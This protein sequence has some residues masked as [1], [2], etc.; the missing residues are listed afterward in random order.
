MEQK[1]LLGRERSG[2]VNLSHPQ[3]LSGV[4]IGA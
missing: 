1:S 4:L 3:G 2:G